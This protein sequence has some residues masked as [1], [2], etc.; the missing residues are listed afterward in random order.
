MKRLLVILV[1]ILG[2]T[3][4]NAQVDFNNAKL[5]KDDINSKTAYKMQQDGALLIDVRTKREFNISRAKDSINIPIFYEKAGQ[6]ALNRNF[7]VEIAKTL[8]DDTS[9]KVI[10]ICRSGSRTK[11]ASNILAYNSFKNVYN[12]KNGFS[13]DWI[14]TNLP[15]E[16]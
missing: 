8:K 2:S 10:L 12:I 13:Y 15:V 9:K 3:F 1:F 6:R 11:F 4:A 5:Y 14:K 16:K 7:L